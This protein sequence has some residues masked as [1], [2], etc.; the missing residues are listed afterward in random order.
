MIFFWKCSPDER[1]TSSDLVQSLEDI[2]KP[3][4]NYIGFTAASVDNSVN[5]YNHHKK[6]VNIL[7]TYNIFY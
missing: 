2:I 3:L 7:N 6:S 4:A 1:P 5:Y